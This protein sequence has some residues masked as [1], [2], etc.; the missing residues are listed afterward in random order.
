LRSRSGTCPGFA[1]SINASLAGDPRASARWLCCS[2]RVR[3]PYREVAD[4]QQAV[5][6]LR[7]MHAR[8]AVLDVEPLVAGWD[9]DSDDLRRG[10]DEAVVLLAEVS[11]LEVVGFSTNSLRRLTGALTGDAFF[12]TAARKPLRTRPYRHLPH[13]GIVVGDQ[14]VTDGVLAWRLGFGFAHLHPEGRRPWGPAALH[15]IGRPLRRVLFH[16]VPN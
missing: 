3:V 1:T 6:W 12:I 11:E 9:T 8:T 2:R 14:L 15:Q 16:V 7:E 5:G 10:V 4:L 13:P